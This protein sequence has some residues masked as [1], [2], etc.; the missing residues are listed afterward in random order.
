MPPR[1]SKAKAERK[2]TEPAK[3]VAKDEQSADR[4]ASTD[5]DV[6]DATSA[7][8]KRDHKPTPAKQPSKKRKQAAST[9]DPQKAPR[10][11]ARGASKPHPSQ[12]QLLRYML[13]PAA[14][15]FCQP[16]DETED[17]A[18]HGGQLRTY[19]S[20]VLNPYEEL[21]CAVI[22][23]RPIS[24]R[25][26]L[27][28]IRTVLNDPYNFTSATAT[29]DAGSET[30]HQALWDARTQ[31]KEKTA[32]QI[33]SLAD[34]VMEKFTSGDDGEGSQMRRIREDCDRDV[35]REREYMQSNVKGLGKTGLDIFFRRV[36]WL[37]D[38][39]Y[40]FVD[41]RTMQSLRKLGL[42]DDGEE[43]RDLMERHWSG[44]ETKHLAGD[45]EAMRKRRAFVTIL[46]R[47]TGCDLEG[48][49]EAL[50]EAAAG[51]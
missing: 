3:E 30:R 13:S 48:K 32:E 39:S 24:H 15:E 33:G 43:L 45:D 34:V 42:P 6:K 29:R 2:V 9:D 46:E 49:H 51:S 36:Q 28:T 18:H 22:L 7:S 21:L 50:L 14:Q 16:A 25:L 19:S 8:P 40:P 5:N 4:T 1:K 10:R 26:G 37:W 38:V 41:D 44:V 20:S 12:E 23:S 17:L 27:R 31:H 11:S 47:A 35:P